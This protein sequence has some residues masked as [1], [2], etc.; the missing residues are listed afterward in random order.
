[1]IICTQEQGISIGNNSMVSWACTIADNNSHSLDPDL[2][3]NDAWHWKLGIDY[4]QL[5]AYK[6]WNGVKRAPVVIEDDVWIGFESAILAGVTIG[7]GSVIGARSVVSTSVPP[8]TVFAG[9]PARFVRLV[10]RFCGW[11]WQELVTALQ[12]APECT[13][14]SSPV[15]YLTAALR[16]SREELRIREL[17]P[18]HCEETESGFWVRTA[19]EAGAEH[20]EWLYEEH[21]SLVLGASI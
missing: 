8:Y 10:P 20:A 19:F 4:G 16:H 14:E 12:G 13:G 9:S 5:G 21:P 15:Q 11:T 18:L 3:H 7:R 6:D 17:P 1:M 2:R